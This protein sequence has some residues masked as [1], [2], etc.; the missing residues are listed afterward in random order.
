[1]TDAQVQQ[2]VTQLDSSLGK[3]AVDTQLADRI[4]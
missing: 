1:M 2:T 4:T 3:K